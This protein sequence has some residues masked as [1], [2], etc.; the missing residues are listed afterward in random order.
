[1]GSEESKGSTSSDLEV[2][3]EKITA[4]P[5]SKVLSRSHQLTGQEM[6]KKKKKKKK[7]R[8]P[9]YLDHRTEI[10]DFQDNDSDL[11]IS[12]FLIQEFKRLT[13]F[14]VLVDKFLL[15]Q[16]KERKFK[17]DIVYIKAFF[18]SP[19]GK[20]TYPTTSLQYAPG[21]ELKLSLLAHYPKIDSA[22][23]YEQYLKFQRKHGLKLCSVDLS[24]N[25]TAFASAKEFIKQTNEEK[26][27]WKNRKIIDHKIMSDYWQNIDGREVYNFGEINREEF[28]E[29]TNLEE[30]VNRYL[31]PPKTPERIEDKIIECF[32]KLKYKPEL[33]FTDSIYAKILPH[34]WINFNWNCITAKQ[35]KFLCDTVLY[36]KNGSNIVDL[37]RRRNPEITDDYLKDKINIL[38]A[39]YR[40]KPRERRSGIFSDL[41]LNETAYKTG[42]VD[43][44]VVAFRKMEE[45]RIRRERREEWKRMKSECSK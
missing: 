7:I 12:D 20:Y 35:E 39:Q 26:K 17:T 43:P 11:P 38:W 21:S 22:E 42:N 5:Q 13:N 3:E 34:P 10:T 18:S 28:M 8:A 23:T 33:R 24:K 29:V 19:R 45:A 37:I 40:N 6:I 9:K 16:N 14:N 41:V 31:K 36:F 2:E 32:W 27:I 15:E 25:N 44:E 1:M 4:T 30:V